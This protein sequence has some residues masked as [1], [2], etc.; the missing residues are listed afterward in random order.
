MDITYT[1]EELKKMTLVQIKTIAK[2]NKLRLTNP[3]TKKPY[4]KSELIDVVLKF[5]NG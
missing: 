1:N 4:S 2:Q 5:I 3:E